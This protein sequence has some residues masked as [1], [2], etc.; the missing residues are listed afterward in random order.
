[1]T[2]AGQPIGTVLYMSPEQVTG[3]QVDAR[4]DLWSLGVL[5]Y[6]ILAGVSPFQT[7]S[8]AATAK[9]I[10]SDDPP[11]LATMPG[12][13]G[14]LAQLVSRLL[15]KNPAERPQS[16]TE[17][18]RNLNE[19]LQVTTARV[20]TK[21]ASAEARSRK[22]RLLFAASMIAGLGAAGLSLYRRQS[23]LQNKINSLV[24]LP[25]VNSSGNPDT[26]Y[27]SD[28]ITESLIDNLSQIPGLRVIGRASAFH[29]KG[30]D[31]DL[32]KLGRDLSVDAVL[33]GRVQQRSDTLVIHTDTAI[34]SKTS[35]LYNKRS[36]R[37]FLTASG[38][39]SQQRRKTARHGGTR[40]TRRRI[41]PIF[42]G[43]TLRAGQQQTDWS[44]ALSIISKPLR[45]TRL[46]PLLTPPLQIRMHCSLN[47][48]TD[49]SAKLAPKPSL[50][51]TRR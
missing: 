22:Y 40:R 5:A 15:R 12:V 1:M 36:P 17:V 29:Y 16:A 8:S 2:Q 30:K 34:N 47:G 31:V 3:E 19:S 42:A 21:T 6:E 33:T 9:R 25:F 32:N 13:P 37:P 27:L 41:N 44:G 49:P 23:G 24:V 48:A 18:L 43:D 39:G 4:S 46:T 26:E 14:W 45:Q 20:K 11:S 10:L 28:G 50:L 35:W 7:E 38:R 51:P